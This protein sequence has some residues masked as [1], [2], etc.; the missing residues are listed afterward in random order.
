[1]LRGLPDVRDLRRNCSLA[2]VI[3]IQFSDV[4]DAPIS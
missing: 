3:A 4:A 2:V 1:M